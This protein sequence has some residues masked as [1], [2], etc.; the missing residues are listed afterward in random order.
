VD[1]GSVN[2]VLNRMSTYQTH[3][4]TVITSWSAAAAAPRV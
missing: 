4:S 2:D 1:V 3:G